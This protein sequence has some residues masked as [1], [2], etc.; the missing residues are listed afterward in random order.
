MKHLIL[1]L[2]LLSAGGTQIHY[3]GTT[4][5]SF[6]VANSDLAV[7]CCGGPTCLPGEPCG[8]VK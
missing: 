2:T 8:I 1:V 7:L 6:R 3:N 4:L 5:A